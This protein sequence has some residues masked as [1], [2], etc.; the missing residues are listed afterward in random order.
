MKKFVKIV[1]GFVV[2]FIV[3]IAKAE[4]STASTSFLYQP[5]LPEDNE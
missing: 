3:L 1:V 5:K 2:T 4:I